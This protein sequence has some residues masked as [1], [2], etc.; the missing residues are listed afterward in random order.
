MIYEDDFDDENEDGL[1]DENLV[2]E[3]N[4]DKL[5][6]EIQAEMDDNEDDRDG[7]WYEYSYGSLIDDIENMEE[8]GIHSNTDE[9]AEDF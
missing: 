4:S 8:K 5:D 1:D 3:H 2:M 6:D 7:Q 9:Y